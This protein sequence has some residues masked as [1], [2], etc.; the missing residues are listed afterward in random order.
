MTSRRAFDDED[1]RTKN[2]IKNAYQK[3][4]RLITEKRMSCS[5][6]SLLCGC[7]LFSECS[8]VG[9]QQTVPL[10][11]HFSGEMQ[12]KHHN[13]SAVLTITTH[14]IILLNS[15]TKHISKTA[16]YSVL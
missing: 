7:S 5:T 1:T 2:S 12:L 15:D 11:Q 14:S 10:R 3:Y 9:T 13:M 6:M 4:Q 16:S 8:D